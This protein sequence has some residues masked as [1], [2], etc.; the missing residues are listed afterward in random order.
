M[1]AKVNSVKKGNF[2]HLSLKG[3]G[4]LP[5]TCQLVISPIN[6]ISSI[7]PGNNIFIQRKKA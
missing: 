1:K 6:F 2:S 4:S 3:A 7:K 5:G